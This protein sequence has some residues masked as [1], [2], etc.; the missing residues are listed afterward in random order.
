MSSPLRIEKKFLKSYSALF[1]LYV[2]RYSFESFLCLISQSRSRNEMFYLCCEKEIFQYEKVFLFSQKC[3][4]LEIE[5]TSKDFYICLQEKFERII[6]FRKKCCT[7]KH[8]KEIL[9]ET[10]D[11]FLKV[12]KKNAYRLFNWI[13]IMI[14]TLMAQQISTGFSAFI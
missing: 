6:S 2:L 5:H 13:I 3:A 14:T 11:S 4:Q 9:R 8:S 12:K 10:F 1:F 7:N